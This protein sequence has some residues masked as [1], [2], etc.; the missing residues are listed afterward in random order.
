MGKQEPL[1]FLC[2]GK[3]MVK[4]CFIICLEPELMLR[5]YWAFY[6]LWAMIINTGV[7]W[8]MAKYGCLL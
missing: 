6:A 1:C 5:S 2:G 4:S 3:A 8:P 7:P